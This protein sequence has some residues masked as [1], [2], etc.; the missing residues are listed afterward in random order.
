MT[1]MFCPLPPNAMCAGFKG[2]AT[3]TDLVGPSHIGL[4]LDYSF[5]TVTGDLPE[6]EDMAKWW[7][8]GYGYDLRNMAY[9]APE[10]IPELAN[11]MLR[12]GY[13]SAEVAGVL[14]Q[15]FARVAR[16]TW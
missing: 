12:A 14:G 10:A 7:P 9:M 1:P 11:A 5:H 2:N 6:G 15:N 13:S 8:D 3:L 16:A 4:G